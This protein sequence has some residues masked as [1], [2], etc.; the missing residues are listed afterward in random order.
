MTN[1]INPETARQLRSF[2]ERIERLEEEIKAI[3]SDKSEVY[4]EAKGNG[5]DVKAIKYIVSQRRLDPHVRT[6]QEAVIDT[7]MAALGMILANHV[8]EREAS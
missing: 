4:S 8:H 5:F 3:N 7:Y 2:V 6:E 1:G